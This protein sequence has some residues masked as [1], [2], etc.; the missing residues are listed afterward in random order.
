[1]R[2]GMRDEGE[3]R[4]KGSGKRAKRGRNCMD[5]KVDST[6]RQGDDIR[7]NDCLHKSI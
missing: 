7:M 5:E 1:M 3:R 2:R 4:R 6:E